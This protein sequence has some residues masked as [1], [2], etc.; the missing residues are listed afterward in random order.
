MDPQACATADHFVWL[1]KGV[2]RDDQPKLASVQLWT[3]AFNHILRSGDI[4]QQWLE[5]SVIPL[6]KRHGR[7]RGELG[8]YR[9]ICVINRMLGVL[10]KCVLNRLKAFANR[11][12]VLGDEQ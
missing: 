1:L 5:Q 10:D 11:R 4:P 8:S 7:P 9:P 12:N 6:Y 3:R 2:A